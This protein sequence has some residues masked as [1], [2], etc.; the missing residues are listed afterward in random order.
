MR[1]GMGISLKVSQG[2]VSMPF[3]QPLPGE[4]WF[5]YPATQKVLRKA[6]FGKHVG[7]CEA[8]AGGNSILL[9]VAGGKFL[10]EGGVCFWAKG[11]PPL[12]ETPK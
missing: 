11:G 1:M 5:N 10:G 7:V 3:H 6:L 12:S 4:T 9:G 8:T 2:C